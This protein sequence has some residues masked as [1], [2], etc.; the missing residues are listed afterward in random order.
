M[1]WQKKRNSLPYDIDGLVIKINDLNT[2]DEIGY[3]MKVPKWEIAYKFPLKENITQI[4]DI[5]L[6]VGRTGRVIPIA[7]LF[8]LRVSG[9]LVSRAT[10]NNI[11]NIKEKDIRMGDYISSNK[12][13]DI[14]PEDEKI[15]I[16]RRSP[17]LIPYSFPYKYPFCNK[18]LSKI[19]DASKEF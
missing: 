9:S 13:G 6:S 12:A 18:S 10:L 19:I 7:I 17:E 14:I 3:T 15:I 16:E 11:D 2:Y 5:E 8:P 1:R 4:K